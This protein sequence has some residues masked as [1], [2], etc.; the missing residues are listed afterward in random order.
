M[1]AS[2][3][4][5]GTVSY[6]DC[7]AR[8]AQTRAAAAIA[9]SAVVARGED[10]M[11]RATKLVVVATALAIAVGAGCGRVEDKVVVRIVDPGGVA[12][13]REVTVGYVN[14]R[15][16]L[17]PPQLL[18]EV[19][20]DE[21]KKAFIEEIIRK[22]LLVL[23]GHR[24][25]F[26]N[27]PQIQEVRSLFETDKAWQVYQQRTV[28]EPAEPTDDDLAEYN[29]L[30]GTSF[31][32]QQL[33]VATEDE[34]QAAR[35]RVT[36]GREDFGAVATEVSLAPSAGGGGVLPSQLWPDI[37]PVIG[38]AIAD[39][40]IGDV[41]QPIDLGEIFHVYKVLNRIE[42]VDPPEL[43]EQ[44]LAAIR[45]ECRNVR[46]SVRQF[47]VNTQ[48]V[49]DAN[50]RYADDA[51]AIASLRLD[52]QAEKII[53]ENVLELD[54]AARMSIAQIQLI[55]EFTEE[56]AGMEFLRY[57]VHGVDRVLTL[58]DF[59]EILAKTP[60]IEG[61]KS[62]S[63]DT[64]K[65]FMWKT[66]S[67]EI[68]E[69]EIDRRGY[70]DT[71]EV[72][73]YVRMRAEEYVVNMTYNTEVGAKIEQPTGTEIREYFR[74][75]RDDY[76]RPE[77]VD[78]R[79]IIVDTQA[80]ANAVRQRLVDG[81]ADFV[82]LVR[83][84]SVDGWSRSR[85][86]LI[87]KYFKGERRLSY[88][89][90]VVFDLEVGEISQPVRAPGGYAIITVESKTPAEHLTFDEAG[91]GVREALVT[92]RSEARLDEFIEEVRASVT[93]EW[94]DD[95]LAYVKDP[96]EAR[97]EKESSPGFVASP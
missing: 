71:P 62:G 51:V 48:M 17:L 56:E 37:N 54:L 90:D 20:G 94:F 4:Y 35:R 28:A 60:G 68:I 11:R 44:R 31:E 81:H 52:E 73:D 72:Q 92:A 88:L 65:R 38:F 84:H 89:Q 15:L 29:V 74:S 64:L 32:L 1:L 97:M 30:R 12:P 67:T 2:L 18:P 76:M 43:D 63:E 24:L 78:V 39:L 46:T 53:P 85:D 19:G 66:V 77:R 87:P 36:S 27:D 33:V 75:H 42:P 22:E 25:G 8:S 79:Q 57:A 5:D 10:A 7:G 9:W 96:A 26:Q 61:P 86:G 47:Q 41:S 40:G 58:G 69:D 49:K 80:E 83:S 82:E 14:Q 70:R 34:A 21:G 3:S 59:A 93:I 50:I 6:G 16:D 91:Q 45:D 23:A 95:N 13:A 55:P